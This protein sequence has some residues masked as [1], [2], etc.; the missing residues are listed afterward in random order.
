MAVEVLD[1]DRR[2]GDHN[3]FIDEKWDRG[4]RPQRRERGGIGLDEIG[5]E[6]HVAL[7]EGDE[8]LPAVQGAGTARG[9]RGHVAGEEGLERL[10]QQ[11][12]AVLALGRVFDAVKKRTAR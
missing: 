11:A 5:R 6:R 2:L 8:R 4:R 12:R 10:E 9:S 7:V 1:D 3:A